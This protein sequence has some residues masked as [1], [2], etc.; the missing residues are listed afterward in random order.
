MLESCTAPAT[1][2]VHGGSISLAEGLHD[3]LERKFFFGVFFIA[4]LWFVWYLVTF[5][6]GLSCFFELPSRQVVPPLLMPALVATA[7]IV[8]LAIP[9]L[10]TTASAASTNSS[11]VILITLIS[12]CPYG[13]FCAV[14]C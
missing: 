14:A 7:S 5:Q 8:R 10:I 2:L 13:R 9:R 11:R 12:C 4:P 6:G 3:H 1:S